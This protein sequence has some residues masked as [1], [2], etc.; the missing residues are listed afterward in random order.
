M[1]FILFLRAISQVLKSYYY[2][3]FTKLL[4]HTWNQILLWYTKHFLVWSQSIYQP[5]F[6]YS[7]LPFLIHSSAHFHQTCHAAFTFTHLFFLPGMFF[8]PFA[9]NALSPHDSARMAQSQRCPLECIS[10]CIFFSHNTY[11]YIY[12]VILYLIISYYI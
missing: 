3:F 4:M 11:L 7:I 6:K 10:L 9:L 8:H 2:H 1:G 5:V 12:W